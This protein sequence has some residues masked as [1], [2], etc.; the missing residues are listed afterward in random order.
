[1]GIIISHE[2]RILINQPVFHGMSLVDFDRCS[3]IEHTL[4]HQKHWHVPIHSGGHH[5]LFQVLKIQRT[6][7]EVQNDYPVNLRNLKKSQL[8]QRP[9]F[10]FR[11]AWFVPVV[12]SFMVKF[13]IYKKQSKEIIEWG[14]HHLLFCCKSFLGIFL[15]EKLV[16]QLL[17][18]F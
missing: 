3:G 1:M 18:V 7:L 8:K 16:G 14:T 4:R 11:M 15:V 10:L 2:I 5:V 6:H 17:I 9:V 13:T 12:L